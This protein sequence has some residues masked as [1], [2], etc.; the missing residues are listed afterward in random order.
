MRRALAAAVLAASVIAPVFRR[1]GHRRPLHGRDPAHRRRHAARQG[2]RLRVA[3][4]RLRATRTRATRSVASPTSWRR[5]T[6]SDRATSGRTRATATSAGRPTTSSPTSSSP[7]STPRAWSSG[8]RGAAIPH[9]PGRTCERTCAA[10]S[11]AT[12]PTCA[13]PAAP[14]SPTRAAAGRPGSG[15]SPCATLPALLPARP[16]RLGAGAARGMVAAAPPGERRAVGGST[17]TPSLDRH[18]AGWAPTATRSAPTG[19]AAPT[20]CCSPT[21]HFPSGTDVR[22]YEL[23]LTIPGRIN[24]I[25]AALQGLPVVNLGFNRHVAWTHTVSTARRFAAYE[26]KLVPGEPTSY[27]VDGKTVR[28]AQAQSVRVGNALAHVLR[29]ALGPGGRAPGRDARTGRPRPPTRW[30]TPT[31]DHF[32][33]DQPVGGVEPRRSVARLAPQ[34]RA[35]PGQSVGQL[36]RR[37]RPRQRLLRRRRRGAEPRPAR[38]STAAARPRARCC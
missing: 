10:S 31:R 21:R 28:D 26:L 33:L 9:G 3:G 35:D 2:A 23:H 34:G 27:L 13:G 14:A 25:G 7:A 30:P 8:W 37:R 32:R 38:S 20:R 1:G 19:R 11:P 15:R 12:T 22:W 16:A 29:D 17:P 18:R 24:A 6:P 4:L 36:D 5:S